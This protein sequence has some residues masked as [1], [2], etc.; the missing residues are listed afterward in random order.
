MDVHALG[1]AGLGLVV[2]ILITI[3]IVGHVRTPHAPSMR[4]SARW[5][6]FYV[7]L[8]V[9]FGLIIWGIYG[10][11]YAGEYFAGY[12]TEYS[13]SVDNLF[14]FI[15]IIGAFRVPREFQQKV[16][17]S[18]IIIALVLRLIFILV[19]AAVIQ[20]FSWVFYLFGAFL[21]YTAYS[22]AREGSGGPAEQDEGYHENAV[23]RLIR[24]VMPVSEGFVGD[25]MLHRAHGKTFITPLLICIFA[26]GTADLM[27]AVD[28]IPAVFGLTKEPYIVFA[29]NAFA[30]LGLRQLYFL[31]D[32]LLD[33]LVYLHY[34][35]AA[36]LGFI[37]AKLVIHAL[38]ENE[39]PF[40]NGGEHW[41]VIPE[42]TILV[43][44]AWIV[45][46]L[47]ITVLTSLA[48]NRKD[49]R[50]AAA[51]RAVAQAR[52]AQQRHVIPEAPADRRPAG[53]VASVAG[54]ATD[55]V[56]GRGPATD[57]ADPADADDAPGAEDRV[58][59]GTGRRE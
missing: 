55:G 23:V 19:G 15:I 53:G 32:G 13:L 45:G 35:L 40:I 27:F 37:G 36:I 49:A 9:V 12:I 34:G 20:N 43:S 54:S 31:I 39:L 1:W 6:A 18:G 8:A 59:E 3:D 21:L 26:L 33:R 29:A 11:Q 30:L 5:T 17:L 24:R 50:I 46:V 28:S 42:P 51:E 41:D 38:H 25:K 7:S 14:V 57:P 16:L 52:A 47:T 44:L 4:E 22:Q 58:D 56:S 48:K 10:G 2:V